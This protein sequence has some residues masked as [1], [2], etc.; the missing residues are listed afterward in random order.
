[1]T[2]LH[3]R[4]TAPPGPPPQRERLWLFGKDETGRLSEHFR[5]EEFH[6]GCA[7]ADCHLT[8]LHPHLVSALQTLRS[9]LGRPLRL[10]SGY[11]CQRHN[12]QV[13]GRRRSYHTRGM[14]ADVACASPEALEELARAAAEVP[15][16]GA[17]GRYPLRSFV[18]LDVRPRRAG[19]PVT[20]S[21]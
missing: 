18:H 1:M 5:V 10:T 15:A 2:A 19:G 16:V 3:E 17:I 9:R 13:G 21:E 8:L 6:C 20:W 11:R 4:A 14:A 7:G 12:R